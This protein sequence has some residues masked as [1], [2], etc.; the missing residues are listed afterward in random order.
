MNKCKWF[1]VCPMRYL[2]HSGKISDKYRKEYCE[3]NWLKCKRYQLEEEGI[4]HS[5]NLLPDGKQEEGFEPPT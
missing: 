3:K 5:D 4:P 1:E 2:E